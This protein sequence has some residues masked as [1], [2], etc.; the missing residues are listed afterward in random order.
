M[1]QLTGTSGTFQV[2]TEERAPESKE[3]RQNLGAWGGEG[4]GRS[5]TIELGIRDPKV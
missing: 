4:D 5:D 2:E 3:G 1:D